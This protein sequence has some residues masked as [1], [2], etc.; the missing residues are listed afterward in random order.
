MNIYI[1]RKTIFCQFQAY[2]NSNIILLELKYNQI[3]NNYFHS[4]FNHNSEEQLQNNSA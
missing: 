2:T 3:V 1:F 4:Y